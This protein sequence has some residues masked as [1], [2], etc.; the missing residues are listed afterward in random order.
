MHFGTWK[1]TVLHEI[2]VSGTVVGPLHL[3]KNGQLFATHSY[4][5]LRRRKEPE[6][7]LVEPRF[8]KGFP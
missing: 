3:Q 8:K 5:M 2:R 1:K 6:F 7:R 4:R